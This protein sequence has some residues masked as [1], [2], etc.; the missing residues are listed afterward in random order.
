[1]E[2]LLNRAREDVE[3]DRHVAAHE[4]LKELLKRAHEFDNEDMKRRAYLELATLV[5]SLG[6]PE[7]AAEHLEHAL[8]IK[9]DDPA[10]L[11]RM[12]DLQ[13]RRLQQSERAREYYLRY[14]NALGI[15]DDPDPLIL[16]NLAQIDRERAPLT[17]LAYLARAETLGYDTPLIDRLR[18]FIHAD[19]Q[20][21]QASF[22]AFERYLQRA[23]ET[24]QHDAAK[25]RLYVR[26]VVLPKLVEEP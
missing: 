20:E 16:F 12:G 4:A 9:K 8:G 17:A 7:L 10:V 13:L 19:L 1:M 25:V 18:G 5:E 15:D 11:R 24:R 2:A 14:L 21:W 6:R 3:A 22:E 23:G 26:E